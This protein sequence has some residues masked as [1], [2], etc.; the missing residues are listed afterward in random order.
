MALAAGALP[1]RRRLARSLL[2]AA[3]AAGLIAEGGLIRTPISEALSRRRSQNLVATIEPVEEAVRTVCLVCHLD[4][5]RSGLLFHPDL[6]RNLVPFL[7]AHSAAVLVQGAEPLLARSRLGRLALTG[8]RTLLAVAAGLLLE[9]E[10]RGEDVP[11]ANDNASGVAVVAQLALEL[12]AD[13]P[14]HSRIVVLMT[15]CEEAGMLGA[16]AFLHSRGTSD[17]LFVNFDNVGG[18][19]TLH[20]LPQE[21]IIQKWDADP[22][23]ASIAATIARERPDLG[24]RAAERPIGLT[25]DATPVLARGGRAITFVGADG[26]GIPQ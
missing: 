13:R 11:G 4:T 18:P 16:Q 7:R 12:L 21:G 24:L 1:H 14:R 5:S 10:L 25:Y 20:Y 8:S 17:W 19:A 6:V 2:A 15:G 9:R 22:G 23:L 3:A 26:G